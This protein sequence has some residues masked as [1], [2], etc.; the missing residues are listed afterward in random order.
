MKP[1]EIRGMTDEQLSD[2]L[3][4]LHTEWR[5]LRF[6]EAVGKLTGTSRFR[7][8]RKDI[9][10]IHSIRTERQM[11]HEAVAAQAQGGGQ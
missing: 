5:N 2:L 4:E 6:Q 9:A 1:S 7:D 11:H 3:N 10:R 8:I